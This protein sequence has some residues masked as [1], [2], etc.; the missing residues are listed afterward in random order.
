MC[1]SMKCVT[2]GTVIGMLQPC[3]MSAWGWR[4]RMRR[5]APKPRLERDPG[6]GG[7]NGAV[8]ESYGLIRQF[9]TFEQNAGVFEKDMYCIV[10]KASRRISGCWSYRYRSSFASCRPAVGDHSSGK[11]DSIVRKRRKRGGC[12]ARRRRTG[13]PILARKRALA[14]DRPDHRYL[15]PDGRGERL[16]I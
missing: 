16:G 4:P 3:A 8:A 12:P 2:W 5:P 10:K 6:E 14:G 1:R 15:H 13:R 7:G 11:Q 9:Q